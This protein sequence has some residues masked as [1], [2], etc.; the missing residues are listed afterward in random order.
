MDK[1]KIKQLV[2]TLQEESNLKIDRS[3]LARN[4]HH[5]DW[6]NHILTLSTAALGLIFGLLP[7]EEWGFSILV[8]LSVSLFISSIFTA[9]INYTFADKTYELT[10]DMYETRQD[11]I[12]AGIES[13]HVK[14]DLE[15]FLLVQDAIETHDKLIR[16]LRSKQNIY[17]KLVTILNSCKTVFF[18][19]GVIILSITV[20]V[21]IY[22]S[23]DSYSTKEQHQNIKTPTQNISKTEKSLPSTKP[24]L[25]KT[26]E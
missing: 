11:L 2:D 6:D 21:N 16:T 3:L 17:N 14:D 4:Q 15:R 20:F 23:T 7:I 5:T 18:L 26:P 22:S 8:I 24:L 25:K 1:D 10:T 9:I 19:A 13:M 12:K